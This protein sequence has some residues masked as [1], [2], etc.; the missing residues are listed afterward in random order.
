MS[1]QNLYKFNPLKP[2]GNYICPSYLTICNAVFCIRELCTVLTVNSDYFL[3]H[4]YAVDLGDVWC[5]P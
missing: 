4:H 5:S 2:S 1:V 3:K